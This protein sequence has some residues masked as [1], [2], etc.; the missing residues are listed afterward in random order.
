MSVYCLVMKVE[1]S[2][3]YVL[4]KHTT[5]ELWPQTLDFHTRSYCIAQA[6]LELSVLPHQPPRAGITGRF[7]H[8]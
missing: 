3:M 1:P 7:H 2:N 5:T 6:S 8:T 4:G